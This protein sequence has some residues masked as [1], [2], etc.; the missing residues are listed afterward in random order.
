MGDFLIQTTHNNQAARQITYS[1]AVVVVFFV[2]FGFVWFGF[3]FVCRIGM[4]EL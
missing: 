2:L 4:L 1:H 3:C